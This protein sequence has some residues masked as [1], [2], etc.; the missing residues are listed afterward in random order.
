MT[1]VMSEN[2]WLMP[3]SVVPFQ[4]QDEPADLQLLS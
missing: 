4:N 1:Q 2:P 3:P